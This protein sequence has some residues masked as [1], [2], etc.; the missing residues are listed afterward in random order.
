MN[1]HAP[2]V[3]AFLKDRYAGGLAKTLS[4][5]IALTQSSRVPLRV[6]EMNSVTCGGR[7]HLA[8]SFATAL[9]APDALFE[10]MHAGVAGINWH[11]RPKLPNAPFHLGPN[12]IEPLPE[13]Y[14]LAVFAQMLGPRA[15]LQDVTITSPLGH[16]VK[17]WAVNSKTG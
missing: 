12:G 10:M 11:I 4:G 13:A 5:V 15:R 3:Y 1:L 17:A 8:E 14:G 16:R 7:K 6:T 9:W 2:G